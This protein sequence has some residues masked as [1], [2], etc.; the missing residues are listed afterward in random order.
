MK[1]TA[2]SKLLSASKLKS[3]KRP[4]LLMAIPASVALGFIVVALLMHF[5]DGHLAAAKPQ[6]FQPNT[7][8]PL[9]VLVTNK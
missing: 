3:S 1:I 2:V 7:K 9:N 6:G 8:N 4:I 5:G